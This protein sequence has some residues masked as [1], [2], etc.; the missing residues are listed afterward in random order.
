MEKYIIYRIIDG[1]KYY[2]VFD[3]SEKTPGWADSEAA[4]KRGLVVYY[5]FERAT[6]LIE[7]ILEEGEGE[8]HIE[9]LDLTG[10]KLEKIFDIQSANIKSE[11]DRERQRRLKMDADERVWIDETIEKLKFLRER[12]FK[13]MPYFGGIVDGWPY[14]Y[15]MIEK[16]R[17]V[18]IDGSSVRRTDG[19][20]DQTS[21]YIAN[22]NHPTMEELIK[23][24][25]EW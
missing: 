17:W 13:V 23:I 24:I 11:K 25:A 12:G 8:A 2:L 4:K 1:K 18:Q 5:D 20:L 22:Y 16:G 6:K 14:N 19:T 9:P 3:A 21:P 10:S 15:I 7:V